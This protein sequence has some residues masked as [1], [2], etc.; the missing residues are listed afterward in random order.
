[1]QLNRTQEKSSSDVT[2]YSK[3]LEASL[4]SNYTTTAK[5]S[6]YKTL[7]RTRSI[8]S[9]FPSTDRSTFWVCIQYMLWNS[10]AIPVSFRLE[11]ILYQAVQWH[12][13]E[14]TRSI[15]VHS[16]LHSI[17]KHN[18][19]LLINI[20]KSKIL[21]SSVMDC[22]ILRSRMILMGDEH[23]RFVVNR[24]G[25]GGAKVI[26]KHSETLESNCIR[27]LTFF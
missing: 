21:C 6:V 3:I 23:D 18:V 5:H 15:L 25:S 19:H 20:C 2:R 14:L 22:V 24:T 4:C 13:L 10:V 17:S 11:H 7:G 27:L 12:T 8:T 26:C 9:S 1:M 16:L